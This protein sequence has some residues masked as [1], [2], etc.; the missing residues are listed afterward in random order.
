MMPMSMHPSS[1]SS[2]MVSNRPT[3][4]P[5][6]VIVSSSLS[7]LQPIQPPPPA[8]NTSLSESELMAS[9]EMSGM[10]SVAAAKAL[11][12]VQVPCNSLL[13]NIQQPLPPASL[14][15]MLPSTS[16]PRAPMLTMP[17][18]SRTPD[19]GPL[20]AELNDAEAQISLLLDSLQKQQDTGLGNDS[21]F[22]N[23][24]T[25]PAA[26]SSAVPDRLRQQAGL[27][28]SPEPPVIT[29]SSSFSKARLFAESSSGVGSP[30]M[31]VL[32]PQM[33][34]L[35]PETSR[36]PGDSGFPNKY[37]DSLARSQIADRDKRGGAKERTRQES[38]S[39][40]P[41]LS[42]TTGLLHSPSSPSSPRPPSSSV[43]QSVPRPME[44]AGGPPNITAPSHHMAAQHSSQGAG[45]PASQL[46]A[47][48]NLPQDHQVRLVR[49]QAGQYSHQQLKTIELAPDMRSLYQRNNQ[50]IEEIKS[51]I[52]KTAKDEVELA[53]LQA[54]QHQILSTGQVVRVGGPTPG[55][56]MQQPNPPMQQLQPPPRAPLMAPNMMP[57]APLA[58]QPPLQPRPPTSTVPPLTDH[59]KK[60]V[61]EFKANLASLPPEQHAAYIAHNKMN[62][63]KQLNF[64]PSQMR[65]LNT[66]P[67]APPHAGPHRGLPPHPDMPYP[68][69]V[70]CQVI[71]PGGVPPR[72]QVNPLRMSQDSAPAPMLYKKQK[73]KQELAAWV[74][75][76]MKKDQQEALKPNYRIPFRGTDDACRRLLRYHV[77]DEPIAPVT[78]LVQ[79]DIAFGTKSESLLSKYNSMLSK[80]HLL[81]LKESTRLCSSSEEVML[82]RHWEADERASL[83]KEK[84]ENRQVQARLEEL[85]K[86]QTELSMSG[87]ER[88]EH[89]QL[90][91]RADPDFG[92]LPE[93]WAARYET[94][95]GRPF[96]QKRRRS[97]TLRPPATL[98]SPP[99]PE[100]EIKREPDLFDRGDLDIFGQDLGLRMRHGS[101]SSLGSGF[102]H[103]VDFRTDSGGRS[104]NSSGALAKRELRVSLT[105]V[106]GSRRE[107]FESPL[108]QQ[109]QQSRPSSAEDQNSGFL[110]LKFNRTMSGRWSASLKR[111]KEEEEAEAERVQGWEEGM[112]LQ[113]S[114]RMREYESQGSQSDESEDEEFSLADVG[115]NNAAVRSMLENDDMD[116][117]D[118]LRF[119]AQSRTS[120]D[121]FDPSGLR[122]HSDSPA[123][124]SEQGNDNDSVQNAINSILD[125]HDR[126]GVQ[127][128]DDLN[129]L[130]GLLESMEADHT[131]DTTLDAAVNSIL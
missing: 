112:G 48:S 120:F 25:A 37:L 104:R 113:P 22:F 127:T 62:L 90:S 1:P 63:I 124:G 15:S 6:S 99:P 91:S 31:P 9:L 17:S 10:A 103:K 42:P 38:G 55:P 97:I 61:A 57:R 111:E 77:F 13:Q 11:E 2:P 107:G 79:A 92:P 34:V 84:E 78:E 87:E 80:Y 36:Q 26:T 3:P 29:S 121:R 83:L 115:G 89:I 67:P 117:E 76:Q 118:E 71:P 109:L 5:T 100:I 16:S 93:S 126:G 72:I 54:K 51:K 125:L 108:M 58:A 88:L 75:S 131:G 85:E 53:G 95:L 7:S 45:G 27:G 44:P 106:M 33:P 119:D 122:F 32:T 18:S 23:S 59:Q 70:G 49:N 8:A 74:E 50:R 28:Q 41:M 39:A 12:S 19:P 129:N 66:A 43:I 46:R 98:A 86:K 40:M 82:A 105:N 4:P 52:V 130:H 20:T 123:L 94:V 60:I 114:K 35:T 96:E 81:L 64:H 47:L 65:I 101:N 68:V 14:A 102:E 116:D 56:I 128:P 24:L 30:S 110:G 69:V 73:S 21:D